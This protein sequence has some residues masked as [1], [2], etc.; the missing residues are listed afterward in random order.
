MKTIEEII[1]VVNER[2]EN[3]GI[4]N[5]TVT[6]NMISRFIL[7]I[8]RNSNLINKRWVLHITHTDA[9]GVGCGFMIEYLCCMNEDTNFVTTEYVATHTAT[10]YLVATLFLFQEIYRNRSGLKEVYDDTFKYFIHH[11]DEIIV[12]DVYLNPEILYLAFE[13]LYP[14]IRLRKSF[15]KQVANTIGFLYVDHHASSVIDF[16]SFHDFS[17]YGTFLLELEPLCRIVPG[18]DPVDG[19]RKISATEILRRYIVDECP[20]FN[21]KYDDFGYELTKLMS[22]TIS[23]WDTFEWRDHPKYNTGHER[24]IQFMLSVYKPNQIV[25]KFIAAAYEFGSAVRVYGFG[26]IDGVD[27][28]DVDTFDMCITDDLR[29]AMTSAEEKFNRSVNWYKEHAV[30]ITDEYLVD[31][32]GNQVMTL[33]IPG[34]EDYASLIFH[35]MMVDEKFIESVKDLGITRYMVCGF[36]IK[37]G[38]LSLRT[39]CTDLDLSTMATRLG[40]G[41][42]P[43]A[44]GCKPDKETFSRIVMKWINQGLDNK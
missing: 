18:I 42:H 14:G 26:Q 8:N 23:Q 16:D 40:G 4:R 32:F 20:E 34:P 30:W 27:I 44:S 5:F 3:I 33:L 9:D 21:L 12:S 41:G 39:N 7:N 35:E 31:D 24:D 37:S 43:Q 15:S 10:E 29:I 1:E 28:S 17:D 13:K 38:S 22:N 19:D 36:Y 25:E 11:P 6:E 2:L